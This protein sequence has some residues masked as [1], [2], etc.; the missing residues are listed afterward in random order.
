MADEI[1]YFLDIAL[2]FEFGGAPRIVR[3]WRSDVRLRVNGGPSVTDNQT[4]TQ[5]IEDINALTSTVD[6]VSVVDA[7]MIEVHFVPERQFASILPNWVPGNVGFFAVAFDAQQYINRAVVLISTD[8][9][10]DLR[11]HLI[12]EEVTQ[13]L[14]LGRDS[15]SHPESAF[16]SQFS[17]TTTFA[18]I[19]EAIVELLYRPELTVGMDAATAG[20]VA[21]RLVRGEATADAGGHH[22]LQTP[23]RPRRAGGLVSILAEPVRF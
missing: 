2:G 23:S 12:R 20:P 14:G 16:Y 3:K 11:N 10:Q 21:R 9:N 7:P 4:M 15:P 19:D 5:V 6:I 22:R 1:D 13:S 18:P 17:L 8:I